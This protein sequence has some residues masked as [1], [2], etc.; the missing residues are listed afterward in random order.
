[1][2]TKHEMTQIPHHIFPLLIVDSIRVRKFIKK[3]QP[4]LTKIK[5][6]KTKSSN[7]TESLGLPSWFPYS[8][9]GVP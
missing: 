3:N 4:K 5:T 7:H 1:M 9:I 2:Y 6:T 8:R